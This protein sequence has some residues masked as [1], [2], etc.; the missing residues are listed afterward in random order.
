MRYGV[1]ET[2][3]KFDEQMKSQ[4]WIASKW[5]VSPDHKTWTSQSI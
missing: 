5:E 1:G 3:T 4:P 2:L